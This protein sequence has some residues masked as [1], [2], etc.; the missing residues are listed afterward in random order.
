MPD[1]SRQTLGYRK[2]PLR[3]SGAADQHCQPRVA[4]VVKLETNFLSFL[5]AR[6]CVVVDQVATCRA[7]ALA[8][9]EDRQTL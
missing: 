3:K 4:R 2:K 5:L 9:V 8:T 6:A 1:K 7:W